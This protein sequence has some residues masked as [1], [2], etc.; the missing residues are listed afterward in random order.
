[1]VRLKLGE[2]IKTVNY[3]FST[4][5]KFVTVAIILGCLLIVS[6]FTPLF[7]QAILYVLNQ[8][9]LPNNATSEAQPSA[10]VVLGGGLTNNQ[11]NEIILSKSTLF[12][13]KTTKTV[14]ERTRLPIIVSGRE[15]P[16]MVEWLQS[17]DILWVIPEKKSFNTCENAKF[18][19]KNINIHQVI[20][21]TD[22]YHMS[23]ARR[24]FALH[25]ISTIPE[26]APLSIPT[27]WRKLNQNIRHS[28]RAAY[29][30]VAFT[31]DLFSPQS[32][33]QR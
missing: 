7:S 23:R 19:A 24:Q 29:E 10:I 27:D 5:G 21:V 20:L 14:Y 12:R 1:M 28:R 3:F 17:Q 32:S 18:V 25:G 26:P 13:L 9:S 8:L 16:W 30:L 33:C 31:R 11:Q 15:A 6:V 4:I 22:S 2:L